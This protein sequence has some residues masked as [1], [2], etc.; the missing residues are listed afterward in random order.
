[1]VAAVLF[2]ACTS[3]PPPGDGDD[4]PTDTPTPTG[5]TA[6]PTGDTGATGPDVVAATCTLDPANVLRGSCTVTL[7]AAGVATVDLT[8]GVEVG[9]FTTSA[10]AVEHTV[11]VWG[12]HAE[13]PWTFTAR[14]GGA[15][16]SGE[17]VPGPVPVDLVFDLTRT[18]AGPTRMVHALVPAD[19]GFSALFTVLDAAGRV[20]WYADSGGKD[21][22]MAHFSD[23]GTVLGI[24]DKLGLVEVDLTGAVL[25]RREDFALPIHHDVLRKDDLVYALHADVALESDGLQY[26]RDIVVALDRTGAEVWRWDERD[27]LDA[28]L[29]TGAGG[30]FWN[31]FFPGA[32]DAWH[33]NGIHVTEEHDV[34]VSLKK[35]D[36]VFRVSRATGEILWLLAGDGVGRVFPSDIALLG[37]PDAEFG[38][39]HHPALA[40]DG[41]L[42]VFDNDHE[43]GLEL[44]LDETAGTATFVRDW[45]VGPGCPIQSSVYPLD[46]G[47][48]LV[49]CASQH[50]LT[51]FD[52]SGV[53]ANRIAFVCPD[54][55]STPLTVRG[56]PIDLWGGHTVGGVTATRWTMPP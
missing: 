16:V 52:A 54:Q 31:D 10:V 7:S 55:V 49:T 39:Q 51:E 34:V 26:V 19:C 5:D 50:V 45:P 56:Q 27:H 11:P 25:L 36:T 20:R 17:L 13:G 48:H 43:R 18:G 37:G 40:P 9:R 38:N 21:I 1:M 4:G 44:A 6:G 23:A 28:T 30:G 32:I 29:A 22:D 3:S 14:A 12:L 35:E 15:E 24:Y 42:T 8:D 41:T 53:E 47:H 33:T 46:D 2:A